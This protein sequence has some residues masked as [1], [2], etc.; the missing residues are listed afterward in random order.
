MPTLRRPHDRHRGLRP[1]LRA[2]VAANPKHDRHIMSQTACDHR[3]I[4]VPL[5]WPHAG[6]DVLAQPRQS[7]RQ[8]AAHT[9]HAATELPI[10]RFRDPFRALSKSPGASFVPSAVIG[11]TINPHSAGPRTA[12]KLPATS[13]PGAFWTPV[14][15]A[16]GADRDAGVQKPAQKRTFSPLFLRSL[17]LMT[18]R[19]GPLRRPFSACVS[20]TT[21]GAL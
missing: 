16:S 7:A 5:R 1:R 9:L 17:S 4:P 2:E 21:K 10:A 20:A 12:P 3:R 19:A 8:S 15:G 11:A 18:L 6:G 14:A 13:C